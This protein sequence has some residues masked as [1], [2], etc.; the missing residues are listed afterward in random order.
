MSN[1]AGRN[2]LW[3]RSAKLYYLKAHKTG[4]LP[5]DAS[6]SQIDDALEFYFLINYDYLSY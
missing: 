2:G 6:N 4:T 5:I 1:T 3:N